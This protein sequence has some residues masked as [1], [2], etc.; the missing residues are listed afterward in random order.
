LSS[1]ESSHEPGK[2]PAPLALSLVIPVRDEERSIDAL[3][4]SIV[5]QTWPPDEIIF[6]DGGSRDGTLEK[7]GAACRRDNRIR[8]IEAGDATPG[9]GR[10]LG[11][12]AALFEWVALTDAG[13]RLEAG[14]LAGL[15]G[16]ARRDP[17]VRVVYGNFEPL[18]PTLFERCASL[19]Y[20]PPRR[21]SPAGLTRGPS[22]ASCLMHREVWRAVGGF[23]DLRAA[24]DLIFM[25]RIR[26]RGF[27][28][29]DAPE[30]TVWW[31]LQPSLGRTFGKFV[32]YSKHNCLAGRARYWHYGLARIY[33]S[34]L[35]FFVLA[36]AS[37]PWWILAPV[38]GAALRVAKRIWNRR[39]EQDLVSLLNPVQFAG[40]GL[41]LATIDLATFLGWAQ[42]FFEPDGA[43][44]KAASAVEPKQEGPC[45]GCR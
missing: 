39:Q 10:N 2:Q 23:P 28:A 41:I 16:A 36:V 43:V 12:A 11:I 24:E 29:A 19:A 33:L 5:A 15:A 37:S 20:V 44:R 17:E 7:L 1:S 31:Q 22:I 35:P 13:I 40:V 26:K 45:Q 27:K 18:T 38:L 42:A 9:R 30:A 25:E 8:V 34:G 6:V 3:L 32:L 4:D 21:E 14:W